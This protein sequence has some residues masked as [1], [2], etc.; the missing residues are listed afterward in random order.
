MTPT[1]QAIIGTEIAEDASLTMKRLVS[2]A[3]RGLV[4][5]FD[6]ESRQFCFTLKGTE[7]GLVREG[8][9]PRYTAMTL[10][11]LHRL[12]E[13]GVKSP[14]AVGPALER[15]LANTDWIDNIGDL[16]LLL[17]LCAHVAPELLEEV[18][19]RTGVSTALQRY[20][21]AQ[22]AHTM[23]LA[24]LLTGLCYWELAFPRNQVG[25]KDLAFETYEKLKRSQ[26]KYGIFAHAARH[27]SLAERSRGW[28]GS[29]ADQVYPIYA[30]SLF[31]SAFG[32]REAPTR[33]LQCA[34]AICEAQGEKGQ[35]WWHYDSLRGQVIEG[36]PVF[37]VHQHAMAPMALLQLADLTGH[38]FNPWIYKGIWRCICRSRRPLARYLKAGL[39]RYPDRIE[40][41]CPED[42]KILF[43]CRPYELG[44]LLYAFAKRGSENR[45]RTEDLR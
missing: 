12:E 18:S 11:G 7:D 39:G 19:K 8:V 21:Q 6:E 44:W 24:W 36:Y 33:A 14:I 25:I 3:I 22:S 10:L 15:L 2:L 26:G 43:E 5:M 23:E 20:R 28:I 40:H 9:S 32:D 30:M 37:S 27:G 29:F 34:R 16:G 4:P 42:L 13:N 1:A 41:E 31:S 45:S 38:D 35:W 17:W